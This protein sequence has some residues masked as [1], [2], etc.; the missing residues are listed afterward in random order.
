MMS[1]T[2]FGIPSIFSIQTGFIWNDPVCG[3]KLDARNPVI[4]KLSLKLCKVPYLPNWNLL[5]VSRLFTPTQKYKKSGLLQCVK[6][7]SVGAHVSSFEIQDCLQNN[8]M[9]KYISFIIVNPVN[10][11]WFQNILT[12]KLMSIWFLFPGKFPKINCN[13]EQKRPKLRKRKWPQM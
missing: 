1:P 7:S 5:V 2:V 6:N 13:I 3:N 8:F 11:C 4:L 12:Q 9:G 10:H